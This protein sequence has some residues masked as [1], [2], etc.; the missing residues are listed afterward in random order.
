[1]GLF[2]NLFKGPQVDLEKSKANWKKMRTLFN[3][4]VDNGDDYK[5]IFGYTEDVGWFNYGFV[6]GSK[7]KV[8][9]RDKIFLN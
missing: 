9:N 4:V 2:G 5:I 1:M 7:T 8:G 6:Y 3:Q